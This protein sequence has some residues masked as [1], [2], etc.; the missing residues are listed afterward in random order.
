MV[1]LWVP[2][3]IFPNFSTPCNHLRHEPFLRGFVGW[4][5]PQQGQQLPC[6]IA[7]D[8]HSTVLVG[9]FPDPPIAGLLV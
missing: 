7:V 2:I 3:R 6:I 1:Q 5:R 4:E 8:Q 9:F